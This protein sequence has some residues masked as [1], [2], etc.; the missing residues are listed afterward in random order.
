MPKVKL[1]SP[2]ASPTRAWSSGDIREVSDEAAARLVSRGEAELVDQ[3]SR[4][5]TA[6]KAVQRE[7]AQVEADETR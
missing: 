5:K 2:S 4:K 7:T 6:K 3:T 1:T